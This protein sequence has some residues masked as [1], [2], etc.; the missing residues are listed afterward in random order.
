M[1]GLIISFPSKI[2]GVGLEPTLFLMLG[3]YNPL[4]SPLGIPTVNYYSNYDN[5]NFPLS[6]LSF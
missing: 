2:R 6:S 1:I 5:N 3:I 4:P